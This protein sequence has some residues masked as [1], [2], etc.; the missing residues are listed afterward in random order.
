MASAL[1][2]RVFIA[3]GDMTKFTGKGDSTY[4]KGKI[5]IIEYTT[6]VARGALKSTGVAGCDVDRV[7][8]GNGF[9]QLFSK[10]GHLGAAACAADPGLRGKPCTRYEAACA[11][12]GIAFEGGVQAIQAGADVVLIVGV[13]VQT[14]LSP[15]EGADA[16]ATTADY[17][18]Q[19]SIDDFVWPAT[20]GKKAK[21]YFA[22]YPQPNDLPLVALKAFENARRN[23]HAHMREN[24]MTLE[25]IRK[26][27]AFVRNPEF[28]QHVTL[29]DCSQVTDGS[30]AVVLAS[31]DGLRKM[32]KSVEDCVELLHCA[33]VSD[34][35]TEARDDTCLENMAAAATQCY[36]VTG[37]SPRDVEVAEM[38]DCFTMAE[39]LGYEALGFAAPGHGL[40]LVRNGV[41]SLQGSLPVNTGGGLIGF[42]H[43]TGAT[44]VKQVFEIFRQMKGQAG[45]YQIKRPLRYGLTA[46]MGGD[47]KTVVVS[48]FRNPAPLASSAKL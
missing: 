30:V 3:G 2:R 37:L 7:C 16:L 48:I 28:K 1:S 23:P 11:S 40:D 36:R 8:V 43:P 26:S 10:Q 20:F 31:E 27:R 34:A 41:T 29:A 21:A 35:L 19:R 45:G 13:E 4:E 9:G 15:K 42:G 5:D 39:V 33:V 32:N 24:K 17:K 6:Q 14:T 38:H 18:R 47:D 46:N 22:K 25:Q 44:G 12:G